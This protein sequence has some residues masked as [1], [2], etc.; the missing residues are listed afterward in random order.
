MTSREG[1][2]WSS[3]KRNVA[4]RN[5]DW[6]DLLTGFNQSGERRASGSRAQP[7]AQTRQTVQVREMSNE[8]GGG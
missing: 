4:N 7:S 6:T 5:M 1:E 8:R 3:T 2:L